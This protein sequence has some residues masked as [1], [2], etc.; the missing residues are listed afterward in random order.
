MKGLH[1]NQGNWHYDDISL[2]SILRSY[3]QQLFSTSHY[4]THLLAELLSHLSPLLRL[5]NC[6]NQLMMLKYM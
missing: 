1:D 6:K 5:L 2:S 4:N 3:F